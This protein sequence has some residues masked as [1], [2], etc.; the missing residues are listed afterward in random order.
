M[1]W[2]IRVATIR[3]IDI[4]IHVTFLFIVLWAAFNWGVGRSGGW[5]GVVYGVILIGL[6][7][8]C[9][10]LHE[11]AHSLIA[12]ASG[13]RVQGITLLPIG[14]VAQMES[15]PRRPI[16]E[17][18]MSLAG[19]ATNFVLGAVLLL[20]SLV[21]MPLEGLSVSVPQDMMDMVG[22]FG[23]VP[24]L[25]ELA[26][27]NVAL[28]AFNLA[29]AFPMDGG[30]ILRAFLA[31]ILDYGLATQIAVSVGQGLALLLGLWGFFQGD[32]LLMIIALFVYLGA[33]QEGE[34]VRVRGVLRGMQA[35]QALSRDSIT[36]LPTD[37]LARALDLTLHSYQSDFPV[38]QGGQLAGILTRE[39]LLKGLREDGPTS[40]V[41]AVMHTQYPEAS[42]TA[43]L[44]DLRHQM[45]VIGMRAVAIVD[46]GSFLGLLTLEDISEAFMMLSATRGSAR[47][48]VAPVA[49]AADGDGCEPDQV[50]Y[51]SSPVS[52]RPPQVED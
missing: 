15:V 32:L 43:T 20:L 18:L 29:P 10:V 31:L 5:A 22:S 4:R 3:G 28:G 16:L 13:V 34:E 27:V 49:V 36:L 12:Q 45:G 50:R 44:A 41:G 52:A 30:R 9:V 42:P 40:S 33:E 1:P 24:L 21:I 51:T 46:R 26:L 19:P 47:A 7:F 37:T 35:C 2:S 25:L 39:D 17:L 14:G 38:L 11:L 6:V 48:G 23:L 8:L